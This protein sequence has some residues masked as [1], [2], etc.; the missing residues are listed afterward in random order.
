MIIKKLKPYK[1][2][3]IYKIIQPL[4]SF[5]AVDIIT[6]QIYKPDGSFLRSI[7]TNIYDVR[8]EINIDIQ[9]THEN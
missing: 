8:R 3:S 6:Y 2:Y 5:S 7:R 4:Y 1:G 9:I